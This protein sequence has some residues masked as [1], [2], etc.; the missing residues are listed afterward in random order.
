ML[1]VP[2][3]GW[4]VQV[5]GSTTLRMALNTNKLPT[6]G[7][8]CRSKMHQWMGWNAL[9]VLVECHGGPTGMEPWTC[10]ARSD[11]WPKRRSNV[12]DGGDQ[13]GRVGEPEWSL[14]AGDV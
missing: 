10:H 12:C 6:T 7:C 11:F 9:G 4:C 14:P 5:A 3:G 1:R 8:T 13:T 2:V